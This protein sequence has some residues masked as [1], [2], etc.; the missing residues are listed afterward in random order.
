M[1][2]R[3]PRSTLFPY[4]TL[5]RSVVLKKCIE[6]DLLPILCVGE[7]LKEREANKECCTLMTATHCKGL[8]LRVNGVLTLN[9]DISMS[10]RGC[11]VPGGGADLYLAYNDIKIPAVGAAGA[12][13]RYQQP[14][15]YGANGIDGQCG[16]GGAGCACHLP[17]GRETH[18]AGRHLE[19]RAPS[20][21]PS[22]SSCSRRVRRNETDR[23]SVV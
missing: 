19:L 20:S 10:Q 17:S 13:G 21:S 15:A 12:Q 22:A 3:P 2:R 5:F 6:K 4:T 8:L 1:I 9:G 18:S 11:Y 7:S 14:G 16:G 23:K